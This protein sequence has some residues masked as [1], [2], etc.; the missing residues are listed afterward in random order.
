MLTVLRSVP[1]GR[2]LCDALPL[3]DA[4]KKAK[5]E[6]DFIL[7][8]IISGK[9]KRKLVVC[10]PCS[11]DN[12]QAAVEYCVRLK[13]VADK[14]KDR[15]FL[16][17]RLYIAKARTRGEDYQGLL[18]DLKEG[19][20]L[21]DNVLLCRRMFTDVLEQ[22]GLPIA[23]ELLFAEQTELFGD[24]VSY[25]FIG[26]R[27]CDSPFFRGLA[28]GLDVAVGVKN[29]LAGNLELLAYSLRAIAMERRFFSGGREVVSGGALC[30]GVLRGFSDCDNVMHANNDDASV[31]KFS[32]ILKENK[33]NEFIMIDCSHANS[34]KNF[35]LQ[36]QN[37]VSALKNPLCGG[38]MLE[39]YLEEGRCD[40]GRFGC[41]KTDS[42][43]GWKQTEEL[44]FE[45]YRS[46]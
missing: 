39:S 27:Q 34:G 28:S 5:A 31:K 4:A 11:A 2:E 7:K 20:S 25:Y 32:R 30:H 1:T 6:N 3:S 23:D 37:A 12:P 36:R 24:L 9:D 8:E 22:T 33:L 42:C 29:N 41:S 44:L 43:M 40:G 26:A 14:V 19:G 15:L 35:R 17:P 38:I 10:G 18:L 21:S 13:S 16:T 45:L 46:I